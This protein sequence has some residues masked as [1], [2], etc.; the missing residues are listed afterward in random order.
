[1]AIPKFKVN[2][3]NNSPE[4]LDYDILGLHKKRTII[5]GE[6]RLVEY[7]RNFNGV[8]YS[9]LAVRESRT[10]TRNGIGLVLYRTL[11]VE[12]FLDNDTVGTTITSIKYYSPSESIDE[13]ID[14]RTNV[15]SDAKIYCLNA[16]GQAYAFDLLL[17]LKALIEVYRDGY[18]QPLIDAV[19]A[20]TKPYLTSQMKTDII[21]ILTF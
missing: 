5:A 7:Y 6:L 15:I 2:N 3:S 9:D 14:R 11:F 19:N 21:N 4:R 16:I 18:K 13:G 12:W 10:F 1:M 20:S 8:T 17:G